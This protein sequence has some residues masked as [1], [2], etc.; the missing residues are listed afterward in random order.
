MYHFCQIKM[1][2]V[3]FF[4]G[5]QKLSEDFYFLI[6]FIYNILY[7]IKKYSFNFKQTFPN[8]IYST[9]QSKHW[10][11]LSQKLIKLNKATIQNKK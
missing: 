10:K 1:K 3:Q 9:L 4:L 11:I 8:S 6:K 7:I 5:I 2:K